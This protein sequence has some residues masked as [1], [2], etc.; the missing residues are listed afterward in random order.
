[1]GCL[2]YFATTGTHPLVPLDIAE[3]TYLLPP[4]SSFLSSTDLIVR[5]AIALQKCK[6]NLAALHSKVYEARIQ[7]AMKFECDHIA[8]I[9][10]FDFQPGS[11]VLMRYSVIEK[12]LN[13][14]MRPR[15]TGPLVV[16]SRNRGSAYILCKLDGS[17]YD[18][19]IAAFRIIPYFARQSIPLSDLDQLLDISAQ[20]LQELEASPTADPEAL[21]DDL[22]T[23][24]DEDLE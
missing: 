7:A 6:S 8:T 5:R 4:P 22:T 23:S 2:P 11:L 10:D 20:R 24:Q 21:D 3:A 14:K 19:P 17:V 18:R 9:H 1:M 16:I 15:Y 13:R 12:S